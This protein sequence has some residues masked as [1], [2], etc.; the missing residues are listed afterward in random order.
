MSF[1]YAYACFVKSRLLMRVECR[2]KRDLVTAPHVKKKNL[3]RIL[4]KTHEITP[5]L[6]NR[7]LGVVLTWIKLKK[8]NPPRRNERITPLKMIINDYHCI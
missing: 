4:R 7:F 6:D 2:V 8:K 5:E 1:N 3:L